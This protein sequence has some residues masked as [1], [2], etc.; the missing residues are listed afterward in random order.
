MLIITA[1]GVISTYLFFNPGLSLF[2]AVAISVLNIGTGIFTANEERRRP[3]EDA[4]YKNI[5]M[6]ELQLGLLRETAQSISL[7]FNRAELAGPMQYADEFFDNGDQIRW[8]RIVY[9]EFGDYEIADTDLNLIL[10]MEN[11][12]EQARYEEAG[13]DLQSQENA[14][15]LLYYSFD[16]LTKFRQDIFEYEVDSSGDQ[17]KI[18][19]SGD[20]DTFLLYNSTIYHAEPGGNGMMEVFVDRVDGEEYF[21]L[22]NIK[23]ATKSGRLDFRSRG[24]TLLIEQ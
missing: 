21:E 19:Y 17:I 10:V 9:F 24:Q 12:I 15:G 2:F 22:Y 14:R 5:H 8:C 23:D 4:Y 16:E 11:N 6:S 20:I 18:K 3:C 13:I 1:I 7:F